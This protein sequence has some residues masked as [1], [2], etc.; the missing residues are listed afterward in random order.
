M[1]T[2]L[3]RIIAS[4]LAAFMCLFAA[5]CQTKTDY[6]KLLSDYYALLE[7]TELD[8]ENADK[9]ESSKKSATTKKTS[10]KK[11][12]S[13]SSSKKSNT[14]SKAAANNSSKT[15]SNAPVNDN[16]E[17]DVN[18]FEDI[19]GDLDFDDEMDG[20][21][22]G[23]V[24]GLN[25]YNFVISSPW[26]AKSASTAKLEQEK[27]FFEVAKQIE[28]LF[29]CT[30]T[31]QG[32]NLNTVDSLR[33]LIMSGQKVADAVDIVASSTLA[34]AS[35]GY[36]VPWNDIEGMDMTSEV[37][38][39][40]YSNLGKINGDYYGLSFLRAPEA[41]MC[42]M[43][44]KGVLQSSGIDANGIYDLVRS[45]QW[46]WDVLRDYAKKVTQKHTL[47]NQTTV[48]GLGGY[49]QKV[50][51][52]LYMSNGARLAKL[53]NGRGTTTINSDNMKQAINFMDTLINDDKVYDAAKYRN[54]DTFDASD[55]GQ[56][57]T[58]FQSGKLGF[59][60]E[61]CFWIAK[62]FDKSFEYGIAPVPMGPKAT[63][64]ITDSGNARVWTCTS[65]NAN[66]KNIDKTV[67]I[68]TLLAAGCAYPNDTIDSDD[69][70]QYDLKKE[71]FRND[72]DDNLEMYNIL[73]DTASVD[74]GVAVTGLQ[75]E[76]LLGVVRNAVFCN[77]GTVDSNIASIGSTYDNLVY[78]S[79]TLN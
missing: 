53:S 73:L 18:D 49:Y 29:G 19:F 32:G 11:N 1:K 39:E 27:T 26:M 77:I 50:A 54:A 60:I 42:V 10:S 15:S 25:G 17:L 7:Q 66:S 37:F 44:N 36:I 13:N 52:A 38:V 74:Y 56:Y 57:K 34:L 78:R 55:N 67:L 22:L 79:L 68:L 20:D 63:N 43:F 64:Y 46:T 8:K 47:N 45:K 6:D 76:F 48:W 9:E 69:W 33:P 75:Q 2:L 58:M 3:K 23:D 16:I 31:V 40:G 62:Y 21:D 12:S 61:E 51:N 59:M 24:F 35:A 5:G 41:R 30:I 70:W 71:Y 28:E 65:T 72:Q 14:S 4:V